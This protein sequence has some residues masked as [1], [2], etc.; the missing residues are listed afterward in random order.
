MLARPT[1]AV[2]GRGVVRRGVRSARGRE[3]RF[4]DL[5]DTSVSPD[6]HVFSMAHVVSG[7]MRVWR[8]ITGHR[9]PQGRSG[10]LEAELRA[11]T[12][13]IGYET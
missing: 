6:T 13:P 1:L 8:F 7:T 5:L 12:R 10:Q 2:S 11:P 3:Y 9:F 4:R